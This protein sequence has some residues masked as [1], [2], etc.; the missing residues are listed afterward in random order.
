MATL[1]SLEAVYSPHFHYGLGKPI[2]DSRDIESLKSIQLCNVCA[3]PG[4]VAPSG[5]A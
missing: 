3:A 1:M 2:M 5:E 4:E